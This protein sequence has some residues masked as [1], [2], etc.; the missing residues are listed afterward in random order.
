MKSRLAWNSQSSCLSLPSPRVDRQVLPMEPL[1][2]EPPLHYCA[3]KDFFVTMNP[4]QLNFIAL[5][6]C[7]FGS[8]KSPVTV[9]VV[10]SHCHR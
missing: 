7:L 4:A 6:K 2:S 8:T 1:L 10:P 5:L 9:T 3:G